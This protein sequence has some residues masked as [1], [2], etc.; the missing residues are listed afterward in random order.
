MHGTQ[1]TVEILQVVAQVDGVAGDAP[2]NKAG[3]SGDVEH[4]QGGQGRELIGVPARVKSCIFLFKDG[5]AD[6][7]I[8]GKS[9][10][11]IFF[12]SCTP[13]PSHKYGKF[14]NKFVAVTFV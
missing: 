7:I 1:I 3:H 14:L 10:G 6:T 4:G 12:N 13:Y 8:T 5:P 2:R 11:N 9:F